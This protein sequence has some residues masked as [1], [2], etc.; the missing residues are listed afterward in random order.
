MYFQVKED[1]GLTYSHR[2]DLMV[3]KLRYYARFIVVCLLLKKIKIVRYILLNKSHAFTNQ[4]G[5][6][7]KDGLGFVVKTVQRF[8]FTTMFFTTDLILGSSFESWHLSLMITLQL[9]NPKTSWNGVS[10]LEK[11]GRLL[12]QITS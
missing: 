1:Q 11:F 8:F 2:S 4:C 10:S 9:M 5:V 7:E 3:K 12:K 6:F